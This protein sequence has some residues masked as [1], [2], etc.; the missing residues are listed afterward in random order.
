MNSTNI[1]YVCEQAIATFLRSL[2]YTSIVGIY[3]G[4]YQPDVESESEGTKDYPHVVVACQRAEMPPDIGWVWRVTA[5]VSVV[6]NA[7]DTTA[8]GH[9]VNV[10]EVFD[11]LITDTI[12][13][14]LTSAIEDFTAL[15]VVPQ[16]Q[17]WE[18]EERSWK[19][20]YTMAVDCCGSDIPPN[21]D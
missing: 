2:D 13:G 1:C 8:A 9:H 5:E 6:S 7:D 4:I 15:Q 12:A 16:G 11:A 3:E 21:D 20:T 18:I 10:T 17:T 14:N 19:C